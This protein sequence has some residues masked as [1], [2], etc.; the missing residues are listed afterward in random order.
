[1]LSLVHLL[2]CS[3]KVKY[4]A[5]TRST[6]SVIRSMGCII[7][8]VFQVLQLVIHTHKRYIFDSAADKIKSPD[9]SNLVLRLNLRQPNLKMKAIVFVLLQV[10]FSIFSHSEAE[11][12]NQA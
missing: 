12:L 10:R 8:L 5:I 4:K 11:N 7:N 1:M 9:Y 3:K 6:I 2:E